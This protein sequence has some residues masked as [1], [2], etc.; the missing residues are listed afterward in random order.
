MIILVYDNL[1]HI[2][3]VLAISESERQRD[4]SSQ[5]IRQA[6]KKPQ[7][8]QIYLEEKVKATVKI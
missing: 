7:I 5:T 4:L 3:V 6:G 1:G 2:F 8:S